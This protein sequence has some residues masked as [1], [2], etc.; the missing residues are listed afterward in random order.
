MRRSTKET[1]FFNKK[2]KLPPFFWKTAQGHGR[3]PETAHRLREWLLAIGLPYGR[4]KQVP[5]TPNAQHGTAIAIRVMFGGGT[6]PLV[7]PTGIEPI[8]S[9]WEGD[10]LAVW[11]RGHIWWLRYYTTTLF[12]LQP[13]FWIFFEKI[14]FFLHFF[15]NV[16]LSWQE[17]YKKDASWTPRRRKRGVGEMLS[18]GQ[19]SFFAR[20]ASKKIAWQAPKNVVYC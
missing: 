13:L 1:T 7:T 10:V 5:P 3:L 18:W 20:V 6:L 14:L 15:E 8:S 2:S 12:K 4:I 17:E 16:P 9:P 19:K 11:L